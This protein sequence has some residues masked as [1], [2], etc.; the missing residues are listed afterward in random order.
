MVVAGVIALGIILALVIWWVRLRMSGGG[1]T[2][3]DSNGTIDSASVQ[4]SGHSGLGHG[5]G[6]SGAGDNGGDG[7]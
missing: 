5:I 1:G 3:P 2:S 6:D 7:P 4:D